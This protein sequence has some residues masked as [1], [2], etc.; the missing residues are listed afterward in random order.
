M[1][2][3]AGMSC[4]ASQA[5]SV[6]NCSTESSSHSNLPTSGSSDHSVM[7]DIPTASFGH[8]VSLLCIRCLTTASSVLA[9]S[10]VPAFSGCRV[11][12]LDAAMPFDFETKASARLKAQTS[13]HIGIV[14]FG[15]FGQFLAKRLIQ[16]GH[17]VTLRLYMNLSLPFPLSLLQR[18]CLA[19]FQQ[20]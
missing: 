19:W 1:H 14:G 4:P 11:F 5:A 18:A 10:L 20:L 3:S 9:I 7:L 12:A 17:K 6:H 13:L 16:Q 2:A 8:Q 15:T